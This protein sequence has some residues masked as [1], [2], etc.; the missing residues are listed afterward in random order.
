MLE[1]ML[2]EATRAFSPTSGERPLT[3]ICWPRTT[4]WFLAGGRRRRVV[5]GATTLRRNTI[6][7]D[8]PRVCED[9]RAPRDSA[10]F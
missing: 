6:V 5:A 10:H 2:R 7:A 8:R 9:V 3:E 1:T 4:E